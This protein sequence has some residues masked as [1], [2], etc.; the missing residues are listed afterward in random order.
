[1]QFFIRSLLSDDFE[2]VYFD[3]IAFH[4][5]DGN[6]IQTTAVDDIFQCCWK[7]LR[8][9]ECLS[10]NVADAPNKDGLYE[11]V[12]LRNETSQSTGLLTPSHVYHHYT[13]LMV[14]K[15]FQ[16]IYLALAP[17]STVT[18]RKDFR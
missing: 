14:S 6:S 8:L 12:L 13:R 7:C 15:F 2:G 1:M 5:F 9:P 16:N 18:L 17:L 11:C 4:E 3:K 10:L